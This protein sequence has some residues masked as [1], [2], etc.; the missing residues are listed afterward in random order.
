MSDANNRIFSEEEVGRLLQLAIQQQ[1]DD[2][3]AKYNMDHGLSLAEVQRI[4]AEA[5]ID[6]KYVK[7]ALRNLDAYQ[8][9]DIKPGIWGMPSKLEID[10][11]VPVLLNEDAM[12]AML[13][14]IRKSFKN[15]RGNFDK[16]KHSFS[17]TNKG[18]VASPVVVQAQPINEKTHIQI[19]ERQDNPLVL[20]HLLG[21]ILLFAGTIGSIAESNLKAF[22]VI[23]SIFAALFFIAR[24]IC[25][26][27]Y[28]KR[29]KIL[30]EL[31]DRIITIVEDFE[32]KPWSYADNEKADQ[33][34]ELD[35]HEAEGYS[36][37]SNIRDKKKTK[38]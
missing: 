26:K 27:I 12:E 22:G 17:W 34:P 33:H 11:T 37:S 20:S 23:L 6:A 32:E 30:S 9:T 2:S 36:T 16:L 24:W 14:E 19:I 1:E 10:F 4:A 7:R 28:Q 31:K 15:T 29:H 21:M 35:L 3:E 5:G 18:S 38:T 8:K 13:I 25:W